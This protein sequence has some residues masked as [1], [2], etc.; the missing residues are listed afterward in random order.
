MPGFNRVVLSGGLASGQ[1]EWST[2]VA[3]S[4][5]GSGVTG[6]ADLATWADT[7]ADNLG[8]FIGSS[9]DNGVSAQ[10]TISEVSCYWYAD[11][12]GPALNVGSAVATYAGSTP[13]THALQTSV[14]MSL[15]TGLSGRRYRG[16]AYWPA[17][18]WT[19]NTAGRF[20]GTE[21]SV[22]ASEFVDLLGAIADAAPGASALVPV[23]VSRA[24]GFL[25]PVSSVA[26]G[27]VPDTQRRR[28]DSLP[29][30]YVTSP[31]P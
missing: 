11:T 24:G 23:V 30:L 26:V 22:A 16:R 13:A 25:T 31:Y 14:V 7:I 8:T 12:V 4:D 3:F 9:L 17:L 6:A 27:N 21:P 1:E 5:A 29:E 10:G 15:R 2:G 19:I 20:A 28:R 18:G